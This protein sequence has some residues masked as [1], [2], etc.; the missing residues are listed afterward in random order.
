MIPKTLHNHSD[1]EKVTLPAR[2]DSSINSH[3]GGAA[4]DAE[5]VDVIRRVAA[6]LLVLILSVVFYVSSYS[7]NPAKSLE[8]VRA[9]DTWGVFHYYLG[10][11]YFSELGYSNLYPCVLEA[12]A[13]SGGHW[14]YV[15][16]ARDMETYRLVPRNSLPPCPRPELFAHTLA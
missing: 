2:A 13:E 7:N 5:K 12:D 15:V 10:A 6:T 9:Y 4:L 3:V 16:G 14:K 8:S 1:T 11:K